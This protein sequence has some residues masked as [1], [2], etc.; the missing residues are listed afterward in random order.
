MQGFKNFVVKNKAITFFFLVLLAGFA[1]YFW[2][3]R[4]PYTQN[5]FL[6]ANVRPISPFVP[7]Y[8][9]DIYVKNNQ[10]VKKGE[11]LFSLYAEPYKL[12]VEK[13][14]NSLDAAEYNVKSLEEQMLK[15]QATIKEKT[16][17]YENAQYHAKLATDLSQ[18][19][20]VAMQ[21]AE[22]RQ[23]EEQAAQAALEIAK[24]SMLVT[25][26]QL[27]SAKS[28]V[29]SIKAELRNAE[30]ELEETTIY[31]N[32]DGTI[33]NMYMSVGAYVTPGKA[34]FSFI[35]TGKW[36]VQAN[37]K[38]TELAYL[39]EGQKAQIR[40][41]QYPWKIFSG[42]VDQIGW[43]VNRQSES[44]EA[45]PVVERE[46]EW[47]LLPQRFPVQIAIDNP[48]PSTPFHLG[49]SAYVI[50]ETKTNQF[51]EIFWQLWN[52]F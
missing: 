12:T 34:I 13:L 11:K 24:I 4:K 46:N 27:N 18:K 42:T 20:A 15:D 40:L 50:V 28:N 22:T 9:T 1:Y 14:Q 48:D 51:S 33:C 45:V 10:N 25:Q 43:G 29:K 37:F 44:R 6:I 49:G 35:E 8:I 16:Y 3:H 39:R 30:I 38:E 52:F 19:E 31:A 21:T 17:Q 26:Q 5:A 41:W 23:R 32:G 2:L 36:W 47:F 7:G